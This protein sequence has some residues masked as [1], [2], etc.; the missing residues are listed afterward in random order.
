MRK[1]NKPAPIV[2]NDGPEPI[3]A[4]IIAQSIADIAEGM[5]KIANTRLTRRAIV[6]LLHENSK[7]PRGQIE[8]VLNNLEDLDAIFLKPKIT[9][10]P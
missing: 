10:K 4:E 3:A 5:R 1:T 2:H 8:L 7:V 9:K 6:T